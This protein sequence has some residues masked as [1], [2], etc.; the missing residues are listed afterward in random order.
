MTPRL[1]ILIP[2]YRDDPSVLL[3]SLDVQSVD[4]KAVEIRIMDDGTG[5]PLLTATAQA[6]VDAMTLPTVLVTAPENRGRSATRNALQEAAK[7]KW[8][9]FLDADMRLDHADF[10]SRYLDQIKADDCDILFGGFD[11]EDQCSDWNTDLHRVLSHSSDCL[12]AEHRAR[13]GAQ[14]VASSNLCVRKAVLMAQPFDSGFQGWGW[15]DSEW[16]ARVSASHRLRHIDNPAVHLGLETTETLL[17]RFA[18]SGLNYR[19]FVQAH[20][21]LAETLPLFRIVSRLKHV[22]GHRLSRLPLRTVVRMRAMPTRFRVIAL[23][24]WRASHYA[25]AMK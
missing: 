12:S 18:S 19:R 9:L 15:E 11:V 13:N 23:K 25:E 7:A 6:T 3:R 24:L 14:N 17:S 21:V 4:P 22:P 16:A 5:D 20:P 1:S 8:V 10:L 2:F